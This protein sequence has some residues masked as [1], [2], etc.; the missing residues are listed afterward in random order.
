[1]T[2]IETKR[3]ILSKLSVDDVPFI[4]A[5]LNDSEW[6]QFIGDKGV[7]TIDD[8]RQYILNGPIKSYEQ[9]GFC[10]YLTMLKDSI[11]PI[12][13]CGLLKGT[14]WIMLTLALHYYQSSVENVILRSWH[15]PYYNMEKVN[16][17]LTT[18]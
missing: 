17:G 10:L 18:F 7:R 8:A 1:M 9:F 14:I 5:L 12:G 3:L 16:L 15:L 4:L 2:I 11:T 6:L 13:I